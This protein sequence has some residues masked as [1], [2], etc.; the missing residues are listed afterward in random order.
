MD[1]KS[2]RKGVIFELILW[3]YSIWEQLGK[4]RTALF[5]SSPL[6]HWGKN[7]SQHYEI[8]LRINSKYFLNSQDHLGFLVATK[9]VQEMALL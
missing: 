6:G 3:G 2:F 5:K 4:L 7:E 8:N 1:R 9:V